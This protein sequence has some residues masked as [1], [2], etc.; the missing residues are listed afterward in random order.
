MLS[1]SV[2]TLHKCLA[3]MPHFKE[4]KKKKATLILLSR[5]SLSV[6]QCPCYLKELC[7]PSVT[8][9]DFFMKLHRTQEHASQP[10]GSQNP[11][12]K[13]YRQA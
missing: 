4:V 8:E 3:S 2:K 1:L 11:H 10:Q 13:A 12:H 6:F 7:S 9:W 5:A